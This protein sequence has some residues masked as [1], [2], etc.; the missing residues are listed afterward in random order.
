[1]N[2]YMGLFASTILA[3]LNAER[4]QLKLVYLPTRH[5][6]NSFRKVKN[7]NLEIRTIESTPGKGWA[8]CPPLEHAETMSLSVKV[9]FSVLFVLRLKL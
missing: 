4:T 6:K 7:V 9:F 5:N 1:M 3:C 8:H 2:I